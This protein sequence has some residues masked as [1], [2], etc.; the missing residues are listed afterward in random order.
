MTGTGDGRLRLREARLTV[1][2]CPGEGAPS[3]ELRA[4]AAVMQA[5]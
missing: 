1:C 3:W 4:D 5:G 2:D